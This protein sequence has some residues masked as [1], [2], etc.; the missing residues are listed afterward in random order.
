MAWG[1]QMEPMDGTWR[2]KEAVT[3]LLGGL[4]GGQW[5]DRRIVGWGLEMCLHV[6]V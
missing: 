5:D 4:L 1:E 2:R 6:E 3:A